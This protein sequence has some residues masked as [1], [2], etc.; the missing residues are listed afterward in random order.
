MKT[1]LS[2]KKG[3]IYSTKP[4]AG[5]YYTPPARMTGIIEF[6]T[7]GFLKWNEKTKMFQFALSTVSLKKK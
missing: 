1:P 5:A 3:E 7:I 2:W 6:E 4:V